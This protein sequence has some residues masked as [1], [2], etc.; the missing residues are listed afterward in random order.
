MLF[1]FFLFLLKS[2][3][4]R[5]FPEA[6]ETPSMGRSVGVRF[7]AGSGPRVAKKLGGVASFADG[8]FYDVSIV[9]VFFTCVLVYAIYKLAT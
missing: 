8:L 3:A 1:S 6:A 2:T 5:P 4:S 9:E 7:T